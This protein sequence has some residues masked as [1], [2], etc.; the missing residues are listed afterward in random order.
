MAESANNNQNGIQEILNFLVDHSSKLYSRFDEV[1]ARLDKIEATL[2]QKADKTEINER[3][4]CLETRV[5]QLG[6]KL[7][8]YRAEQIGL[9]RKVEK[10]DHQISQIAGKIN[11]KL[12][13]S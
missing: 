13:P 7:D 11:L 5:I 2:E 9:T 6:D 10:H 8:N 4:N 1:D 3:F 12:N